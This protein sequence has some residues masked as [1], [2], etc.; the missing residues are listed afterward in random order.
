MRRLKNKIGEF[1]EDEVKKKLIALEKELQITQENQ[2]LFMK[3]YLAL[4]LKY[5]ENDAVGIL[6]EKLENLGDLSDTATLTEKLDYYTIL[7]DG[8]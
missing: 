7:L 3:K 2:L 4:M 1:L 5:D 6:N 8:L